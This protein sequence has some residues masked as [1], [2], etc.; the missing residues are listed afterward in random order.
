MNRIYIYEGSFEKGEKG[1]PL[2]RA[3]AAAYGR[4][5]DLSY[6]FA[7]ANMERTE[8]GKPFFV[9]LP[10]EFSLSHSGPMWMCMFGS[11]PCGLDLQMVEPGRG[12][13]DICRRRYT[14]EEQH[15]VALWGIEGFYE[16]WTRKEA[17]GKCT[18]NG[19]FSE[20]PSMVDSNSDLHP[21]IKYDGLTYHFEDIF[22][23]N[24]IKCSYCTTNPVP[25]E[26]RLLG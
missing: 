18:G 10:V 4:E 25:V 12:W 13:E 19:I 5:M 14:K 7:A 22:L 23:G 2:I 1:W 3:A 11:H 21:A 15:Y 9:D 6:D 17:F 16:I 20:M 26:V 8:K 24:S